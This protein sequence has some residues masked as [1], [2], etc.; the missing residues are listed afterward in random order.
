MHQ[1]C[2]TCRGQRFATGLGGMR[3]R[4]HI[5]NGV[6]YIDIDQ[7]DEHDESYIEE[8]NDF[9]DEQIEMEEQERDVEEPVSAPQKKIRKHRSE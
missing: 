2:G 7:D 5:C 9:D 6:G 1:R 3:K 8:S 4:C